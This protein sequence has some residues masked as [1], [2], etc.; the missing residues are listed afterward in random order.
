MK[1]LIIIIIIIVVAAG[2]FGAVFFWKNKQSEQKNITNQTPL[3]IAMNVWAGYA[4][5]F[6]AQEKGF[7]EKNGVKVELILK[8]NYNETQKLYIDGQVDGIFQVFP[9]AVLHDLRGTPMSVIYG[10]DYSDEGDAIIGKKEFHNLSDLKGKKIGIDS[11]NSFSHL[12]VAT[13]LKR[14]GLSPSEVNLVEVPAGDVLGALESGKIDAGHT[15]EPTKSQ[16]LAQGYIQLD[17][18][19]NYPGLI[20]DVLGF[21]PGV[22][23][24]RAADVAAVVKSLFEATDF[25]L[26]NP[27]E[28]VALMAKAE[29]L[30]EADIKN[31]LAGV[32]LLDRR[33]NQIAFTYAAG[34]ESL[35]SGLLLINNFFIENGLT[36]KVLD[37]T[38]L[39]DPRFIQQSP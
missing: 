22:I 11:L 13:A 36:K 20:V 33:D 2:I 16:A 19:G 5:T 1:K 6:I 24:N 32:H 30:S 39:I 27:D 35:Y 7:F 12:F 10:A 23:K 15:W 37:F 25:V 4:H 34:T 8:E 21:N 9:D 38:K 3:K 26:S 18:A 31:G 28:A 17:K 14:A 29:N